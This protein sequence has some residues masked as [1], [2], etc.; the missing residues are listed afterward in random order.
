[1]MKCFSFLFLLSFVISHSYS[2]AVQ[3]EKSYD[4]TYYTE[5]SGVTVDYK[6]TECN[7]PSEGYFR[8]LVLLRLTNNND[9]DVIVDWDIVKW[10]GLQCVNCDMSNPEQHRTVEVIANSIREG[11]C[12]LDEFPRMKLFS[13]FLNYD[14]SDGELTNFQLENITV[15]IK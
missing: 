9:Y 14:M 15:K 10:Y 7:I 5:V 3:I 4:W 6:F 13:K 11:T 8:E 1:M 12:A 2:Q